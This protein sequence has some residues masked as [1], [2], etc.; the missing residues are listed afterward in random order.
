[1][2]V[3]EVVEK[4]V[5]DIESNYSKTPLLIN[6]SGC[7][8]AGKSTWANQISDGFRRS[9][10]TVTQVSEDD[11][12][13]SRDQR[14]KFKDMVYKEGRWKGKTYWENHE[15]W[16]RL[17][18][19][20][21]VINNLSQNKSSSFKPYLRSTGDFSREAEKVEPSEIVVFETSIFSELFDLVILIHVKDEILLQRK[22]ERDRD[23][24]DKNEIRKYHKIQ[25][26]FWNK[27]KPQNPDYIIDNNDFKKPKL[28]IVKSS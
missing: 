6:I 27:H 11:F 15:N 19:M 24:R 2:T 23:L 5:N 3:Q 26:A 21:E 18:L 4:L 12:L 10:K 14:A 25:L 7:T 13:E 1:M 8:G 22:L 9:G 28:E 16:L 20:K 17:E